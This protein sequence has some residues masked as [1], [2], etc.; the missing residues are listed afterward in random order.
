MRAGLFYV[1]ERVGTNYLVNT[2]IGISVA[3]VLNFLGY[4]RFAFKKR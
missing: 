3:I 1:I 4:D 2:L